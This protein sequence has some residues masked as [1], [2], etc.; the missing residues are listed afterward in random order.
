MPRTA[1]APQR[2]RPAGDGRELDLAAPGI[3]G[4]VRPGVMPPIGVV[5]QRRRPRMAAIAVAAETVALGVLLVAVAR[6]LV[7]NPTGSVS[8]ALTRGGVDDSALRPLFGPRLL[9]AW[10]LAPIALVLLVL[11][12]GTY[13]RRSAR[14]VVLTGVSWPWWRTVYKPAAP[15]SPDKPATSPTRPT[16]PEHTSTTMNSATANTTPGSQHSTKNQTC[17]GPLVDGERAW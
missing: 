4:A 13:I 5:P 12:A 17:C 2:C 3:N 14:V 1:R 15:P 8:M 6:Q 9:T 16:K 11:A 10:Q 7:A